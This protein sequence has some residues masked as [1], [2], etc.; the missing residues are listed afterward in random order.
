MSL[1]LETQSEA[2][3]VEQELQDSAVV[4]TVSQHE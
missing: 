2:D 4:L 3:T 1:P